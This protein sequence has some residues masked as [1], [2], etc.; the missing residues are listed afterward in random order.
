MR[1]ACSFCDYFVILSGTSLR[2]VNA[3][4]QAIEEDSAEYGIKSLSKVSSS[5]ESGWIVLDYSDVITHIFYKP[6]REFYSLERLWSDAK[7]VN[8]KK[9]SRV[10]R[11]AHKRSV[12]KA[13]LR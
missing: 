13:K 3:I 8:E 9:Y 10:A 4:A 5:D 1:K 11:T 2:Q 7:R 12:K 6:M